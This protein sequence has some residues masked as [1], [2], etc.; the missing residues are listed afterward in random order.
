M[1]TSLFLG[2]GAEKRQTI[3]SAG[4]SEFADYGY[5]N[6]STNRIVKKAGISKGS[7]F[8]YFP[9]KEDFYFYI[10]DEITSELI[11]GLEEK[12]NTLSPDLFQRI[13]QYAA[14]EFSWYILYPEKSKIIVRAFTKS[15]AE[16]YRKTVLR[17]GNREQDI[18]Y[19]F[20]KDIDTAPFRWDRQKTIDMIKWFLKG[21]NDDFLTKIQKQ[22]YADFEIIE[23]EYIKSLSEYL[24]ILKAGIVK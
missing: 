1:P 11:S 9:T 24:E 21:Y 4:V 20:L 13:I 8:K 5:E 6:S 17:Y 7:L 16:I 2:L 10:L 23:T 14:L 18:Y 3:F 22:D 12:V 15:D 19:W